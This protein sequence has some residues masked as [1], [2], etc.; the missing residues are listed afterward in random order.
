MHTWLGINFS[1][2]CLSKADHLG[3]QSLLIQFPAIHSSLPA[4]NHDSAMVTVFSSTTTLS[5]GVGS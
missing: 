4:M 2:H 1:I 5:S 3:W